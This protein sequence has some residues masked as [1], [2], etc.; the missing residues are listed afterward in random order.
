MPYRV[1]L[2]LIMED[3]PLTCAPTA[4]NDA[5]CTLKD[6]WLLVEKESRAFWIDQRIEKIGSLTYA[7]AV[8]KL[9]DAG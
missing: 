9:T 7:K 4:N 3:D 8:Q 6:Y 5:P 1:T 2:T